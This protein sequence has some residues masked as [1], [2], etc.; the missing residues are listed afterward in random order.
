MGLWQFYFYG[1]KF[2]FLKYFLHK[3]HIGDGITDDALYR[4][5]LGGG[6]EA[7]ANRF[8]ADLLI[9]NDLVKKFTKQGIDTVEALA[10]KFNVS[11][12]AMA[13]KLGIPGLNA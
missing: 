12:T 1:L 3:E 4:S 8:A 13:I 2:H 5:R 10:R 9:P 7:Q 11:E 6:I